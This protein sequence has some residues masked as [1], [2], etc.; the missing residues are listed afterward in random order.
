MWI[1]SGH[2]KGIG[3]DTLPT[4]SR[5]MPVVVVVMVV[6]AMVMVLRKS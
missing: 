5:S 2:T 1:G 3:P 4:A 6:A